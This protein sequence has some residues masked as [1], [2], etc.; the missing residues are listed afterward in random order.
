MH[1]NENEG[2]GIGMPSEVSV[3]CLLASARYG[4]FTKAAEELYM[5]R[6]AVSQQIAALERE[7][8]AKLFD[9]TTAKV[10]PTPVGELYISF[11]SDLL[12]QW[13][14][15]QGKAESILHQ[16]GETIRIGCL[17]A[18]DLGD[19]L[20]EKVE[21]GRAR[22][23]RFDIIWERREAHELLTQLLEGKQDIIFVFDQTVLSSAK[24]DS[25]DY[26]DFDRSQ[27]VI[28][29]RK[30]HPLVHP[31]A[32]AKDFEQEPC[33]L[34]EG[35]Q[36]GMQTKAD[37][38]RDFAQCGLNFTNVQVLPNRESVQTMVESGHGITTCTDM[39]RFIHYPNIISYPIGRFQEIYCV[40]RKNE[41]RPHIQAFLALLREDYDSQ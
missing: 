38:L 39:E 29:V 14:E 41:R 4:S 18:T 30:N 10:I 20:L 33:Y 21:E 9:R 15:V 40:W 5:T 13:E 11:F 37:F 6:Q 26:F 27:G 7:L 1:S 19:R 34:A 24:S 16:Q 3:R 32:S 35:M 22:G 17:Y 36:P 31:G 12:R 2:G 8:N 23:H 28:A 25:L